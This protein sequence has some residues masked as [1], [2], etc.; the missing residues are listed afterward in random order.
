MGVTHGI[1]TGDFHYPPASCRIL[2]RLI[3][4]V[5]LDNAATLSL[6]SSRQFAYRERRSTTGSLLSYSQLLANI[7]SSTRK[8]LLIRSTQTSKAPLEPCPTECCFP[9][10]RPKASDSESSPGYPI[11][12]ATAPSEEESETHCLALP[13]QQ[14]APKR[15]FPEHFYS[16]YSSTSL[17]KS[18]RLPIPFY[19]FAVKFATQIRDERDGPESQKVLN[20]F[21]KW[22]ASVGLRLSMKKRHV[23]HVTPLNTEQR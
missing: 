12:C 19:V 9:C 4:T 18:F 3:A 11:S 10:F 21:T 7:A 6:I 16:C 23:T 13:V 5:I 8:V 22:A 17:D 1:F 14:D 2:E 15:R 20:D